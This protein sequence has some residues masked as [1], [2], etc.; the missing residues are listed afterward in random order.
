MYTTENIPNYILD[1][2]KSNNNGY[3]KYI[4]TEKQKTLIEYIDDAMVDINDD[5]E[6]FNKNSTLISIDEIVNGSFEGK[7]LNTIFEEN[8]C[9]NPYNFRSFESFENH[10]KEL[11]NINHIVVSKYDELEYFHNVLENSIQNKYY[12]YTGTS[13]EEI[14]ETGHPDSIE[15]VYLLNGARNVIYNDSFWDVVNK[16]EEM[17][18]I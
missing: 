12:N 4:V 7:D 17:N 11:K 2:I 10:Y 9:S 1:H 15:S 8:G 6:K 3:S 18:N 5:I 14:I 16:F 13:F